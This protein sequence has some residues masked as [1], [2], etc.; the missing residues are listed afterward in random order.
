MVAEFEITKVAVHI[1]NKYIPPH[2][3][4]SECMILSGEDT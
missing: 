2:A 3:S 1:K 4:L